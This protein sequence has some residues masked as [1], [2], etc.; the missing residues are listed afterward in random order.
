MTSQFEADMRKLNWDALRRAQRSGLIKGGPV[1]H[2]LELHIA[3]RYEEAVNAISLIPEGERTASAWRVLG[4]A[5]LGRHDFSKALAAHRKALADHCSAASDDYVNIAAVYIAME[6]YI[7]AWEAAKQ[8]H[9]LAPESIM[10]WTPTIA[11]LNRTGKHEELR[12]VI[13]DLLVARPDVLEHPVFLDHLES[14]FDFIGVKEII[15]E[16]KAQGVA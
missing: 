16:L 8:A 14:D 4:H 9:Q 12:R 13:S 6:N 3:G 15:A 1:E 2:A 7:D 5:E 11:I 10:P